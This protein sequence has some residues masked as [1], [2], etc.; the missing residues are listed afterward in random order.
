M[1]LRNT[2]VYNLV[3]IALGAAVAVGFALMLSN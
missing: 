2:I 3:F 1:L